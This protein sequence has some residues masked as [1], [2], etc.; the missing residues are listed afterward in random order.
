[1]A[2]EPQNLAITN[3]KCKAF[4]QIR[5]VNAVKFTKDFVIFIVQ[6]INEKTLQK[7]FFFIRIPI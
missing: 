2:I 1:M 5:L 7:P 4:N 3:E 6:I